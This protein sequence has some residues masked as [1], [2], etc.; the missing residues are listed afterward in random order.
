LSYTFIEVHKDK[1]FLHD[2]YGEYIFFV[3]NEQFATW[4]LTEDIVKDIIEVFNGNIIEELSDG[5][6]R[7]YEL[8][9]REANIIF[10]YLEDV[11]LFFYSTDSGSIE[12][13][14]KIATDIDNK[15]KY[16]NA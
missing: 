14:N 3:L 7:R 16:M 8:N 11:G 4:E 2:R 15:L 13:L 6:V 5:W 1:S 12:F 9:F 10:Y